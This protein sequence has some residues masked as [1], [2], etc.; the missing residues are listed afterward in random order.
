MKI[1][2][3]G[4]SITDAERNKSTDDLNSSY[5]F[6]YV[7]QIAGNLYRKSPVEYNIIN[8]GISGNRIVDLYARVKKDLWN[9]K[10]D[11]VSILIGI[12]DIWHDLSEEPNGVDVVRFE[13]I[14]RMLIDDT[15][16]VLPNLKFILCEPFVLSG[17]ATDPKMEHFK[18]V[19]DYADAV[20]R[21]AKDYNLYYLPLQSVLDEAAERYGAQ[22]LLIDG[23][24]PAVQGATII[25]D[26][27]Q[28]LF[29]KIENEVKN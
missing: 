18:T 25:A 19:A 17:T 28:K 26:E 16:A 14:Y 2:F 15:L 1:L 22:N 5:G 9:H 27:W 3:Y 6:G 7:M 13:K 11:L 10:P 29:D 23:V 8:R 4:D 12:N 21:I 20:K 24:H